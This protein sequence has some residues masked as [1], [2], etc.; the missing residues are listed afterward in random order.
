MLAA[1][2]TMITKRVC[3]LSLLAVI[4]VGLPTHGALGI[5]AELAKK[6]QALT[7]KA[8][9]PRQIGNPAAGSAVGSGRDVSAYFNRCVANGAKTDDQNSNR[10]K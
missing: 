3:A 2:W 10:T 1:S 7:A 9:P 8:F 4:A 6:C 5:T